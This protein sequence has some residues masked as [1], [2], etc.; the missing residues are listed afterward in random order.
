MKKVLVTGA[1]GFIGRQALPA[2]LR[3]G[4]EVHA[5][6]EDQPLPEPGGVHWHKVDLLDEAAVCSMAKQA[7]PEQL[8]HFAWYVE[9]GKYTN[10]PR[11]LD[12]VGASLQLLRCL[13]EQGLK[14]AV[15]A[16]TCMEYD[17]RYEHLAERN[18]PIAPSTLYGACKNAVRLVL[19]KY[20]ETCGFSAAWG[21]IFFLYG[22]HEYPN[23]LVSA[24]I[25]ALLSGQEAKCTHGK[26]IRDFMHVEDVG[27][28]FAALLDSEVTGPVNIACGTPVTIRHVVE[29]I[30]RLVG[31]SELLRF[32]AY[33]ERE[34]D[35]DVLTA[36]VGRLHDEVGWSPRFDLESGLAETI[37]WWR[38][39]V[40]P[41][42]RDGIGKVE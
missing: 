18:T 38:Q 22:P 29:T 1:T 40:G 15:L 23:R 32:G 5:I 2:L 12:W 42:G 8:L 26:Q 4:Y 41:E 3:R 13:G 39:G 30:G 7:Q 11:N 20:G 25:R 31:R 9:P 21:R 37:K 33:P 14:R 24:V 36:D 35:P 16:G 34:N 6:T 10:S 27:D 19:D 28:A 17:W